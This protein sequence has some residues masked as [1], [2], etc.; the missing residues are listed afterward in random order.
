L[1]YS[2]PVTLAMFFISTVDF[3]CKKRC[4]KIED[5]GSTI[6]TTI[7]L[8]EDLSC[9]RSCVS[10]HNPEVDP[11]PSTADH[12]TSYFSRERTKGT[13]FGG[14]DGA[15]LRT[16][17][18]GY[19]YQRRT[20]RWN[21]SCPTKGGITILHELGQ[22]LKGSIKSYRWSSRWFWDG[23]IYRRE[24]DRLPNAATRIDDSF[25]EKTWLA[26][27][28]YVKNIKWWIQRLILIYSQ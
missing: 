15:R 26:N 13:P 25:T 11:R 18:L 12:S 9:E 16:I 5:R 4:R 14:G 6:D 7:L 21:F 8:S 10:W 28:I 22:P 23:D 20:S 2:N 24:Y 19:L 3:T 1:T 17:W 27:N